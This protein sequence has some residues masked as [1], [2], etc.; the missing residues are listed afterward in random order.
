M[1]NLM[2]AIVKLRK[3]IVISFFHKF[4]STNSQINQQLIENGQIETVYHLADYCK[5]KGPFVIKFDIV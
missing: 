5:F 2:T 3:M 1:S 4:V